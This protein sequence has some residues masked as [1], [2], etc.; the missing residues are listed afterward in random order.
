MSKIPFI[1]LVFLLNLFYYPPL[2]AQSEFEL[3]EI[4]F[5]QA[6]VAYDEGRYADAVRGLLKAH[7]LDSQNMNVIYYLGLSLN[8]QNK[9]SE[10][11]TYLRG[12]LER[13]P[14][15][16][17]MRFQLG[18]A[19]HGQNN[20][21][22]ALRE[23][24]AVY[25]IEPERDDIGYYIGLCYYQK[26]DYENALTYFLRN[27]SIN[28]RTRQLNQL[29]IGLTLRALGRVEEAIE[30]L[31]EAIRI[32][33]NSPI[34]GTTQQLLTVLRTV[35]VEEKPF[36]LELTSRLQ[37]D[38]NAASFPTNDTQGIGLGPRR[39]WGTLINLRADYKLLQSERWEGTATYNFL[40]TLNYQL[41]EF[42]LQD[43]LISGNLFYKNFLPS[44]EP[45]LLGT[46][47]NYDILLSGNRK[48]LERPTGT[49]SFTLV[50]NPSNFSTAFFRLQY[51]DF[52]RQQRVKQEKRD[53][54][55]N[56]LG[57]VHSVRFLDSQLQANFGYHYDNEDAQGRNWRYNGHKAVAGL[58][59]SLPW[60]M[61]ATA[62]FEFHA[63]FHEGINSIFSEHRVDE[64]RTTLVSLSKD[65][66]RNL[67]VIMEHLWDTT[68]STIPFYKIRRQIYSV[69]VTWRY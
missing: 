59:I 24:L 22:A 52:F 14:R 9:Y 6:V 30:E 26:E 54:I 13:E 10:A 33:P 61:N 58:L 67:T 32:E 20:F 43:H 45:F 37:Y 11:E 65:I 66:T 5:S 57:L 68:Q 36:R 19:L 44:G 1:S 23:F 34:V 12:G 42:D 35:R 4:L 17:D 48:F 16:Y 69:G 55:N 53:A 39:S 64:Q 60:E 27:I 28:I 38:S 21:A 18:V 25:E 8:R 40:Q 29:Y 50:E 56:L 47:F 63:R 51:K 2:Y 31:T 62:N 49:L 46:Q 41:H 3:S 15:N 7:E